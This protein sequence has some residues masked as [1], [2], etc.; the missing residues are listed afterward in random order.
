MISRTAD[1]ASVLTRDQVL[2]A[3]VE[4]RND[5]VTGQCPTP[6]IAGNEIEQP[7]VDDR[8]LDVGHLSIPCPSTSD[9]PSP[10]SELT[11][12]VSGVTPLVLFGSDDQHLGD[13]I[14]LGLDT[15]SGRPRA[16]WSGVRWITGASLMRPRPEIPA[17]GCAA[18]R[19]SGRMCPSTP[20]WSSTIRRFAIRSAGNIRA[21]S[22]NV[23]SD[24]PSHPPTKAPRG[25]VAHPIALLT[26]VTLPNMLSSA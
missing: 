1:P 7:R 4:I 2:L 14:V 23:S 3:Q 6:A 26:V 8:Y 17:A 15:I 9:L 10:C 13:A 22:G 20:L 18:P 11:S 5:V 25:R 24:S 12:T 16:S 19:N 21:T